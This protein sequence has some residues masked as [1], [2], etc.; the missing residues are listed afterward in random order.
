[1]CDVKGVEIHDL[2]GLSGP[3]TKLVETVSNGIGKVYEPLHIRRT[4]KAKS[5]EISIISAA[6]SN[7]LQ[8]PMGYDDGKISIDTLNTNELVQRAQKR[9]WYQEVKKQQNIESV[10]ENAYKELK[11]I[12]SVSP[13]PVDED[14][15]A[16]LFQIVKDVNSEEMQFVWGKILAGEIEQPGSFSLRTLDV[17]RNI[18]KQDAEEFQ[19][20]VPLVLQAEN[21]QFI[22]SSSD[23]LSQFGITFESILGLDECGLLNSS[24]TL[25]VNL[26]ATNHQADT[27]YNKELFIHVIGTD[28]EEVNIS[29]GMYA[30]T[31]AGSELYRILNN[32][33]VSDTYC[34][35][36]AEEIS[37]KDKKA[38]VSVHRVNSINGDTVDYQEDPLKT[39][40]EENGEF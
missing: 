35:A 14:W 20:V 7:N 22:I 13:A 39:F 4:A 19:K 37:K 3:L 23:I 24:G 2:L 15:I 10:I 5:E 8:L 6:I 18:T 31:R 40:G 12:D 33:T 26:L 27:T 11:S 34:F 17:I 9:F 29:L 25:S 32:Y 21:C 16:R 38:K 1:M 30:L 36:V 28:E